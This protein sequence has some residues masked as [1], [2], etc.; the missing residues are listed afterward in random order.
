M[1]RFIG[2][3]EVVGRLG[4]G[5]SGAVFE[6]RDA[7][8]DRSLAIKVLRTDGLGEDQRARF[9]QEAAVLGLLEHEGIARIYHGGRDDDFEGGLPY[10]AMEL[11]R[12]EPIDR[13]A[14]T[15]ELGDRERIE[16]LLEL[17]GAIE[18]AHQ[19]GVIHR[20]LK[21]SN[22]L[23]TQGGQVKV[24]DFGLARLT[25]ADLELSRGQDTRTGDVLGTLPYMSPEQVAARPAELDTRTDVYALGVMAYELLAGVQ[26]IETRSQSL[27]EAARRILEEE[28]TT[29]GR[30]DSRWRGDLEIIVAKA[31]AKEKHQR[32]G[33]VGDFAR[34]LQRYLDH[35]PIAARRPTRSYQIRM[36]ARRQ[37]GLV[38]GLCLA[39]VVLLAGLGTSGSLYLQ[40]RELLA[41]TEVEV[42]TA[43]EVL[44]FVEQLFAN[45][46]PNGE[47]LLVKD[48]VRAA[49]DRIQAEFQQR[50]EVR[51]RLLSLLGRSFNQLQLHDQAMPLLEEALLLQRELHGSR[52][53]QVAHVL[54]QL[55]DVAFH[56][57]RVGDAERLFGQALE[58][59]RECLSVD[60]VIGENLV[61]LGSAM[62]SNGQIEQGGAL[63]DEGVRILEISLG[64][65]HAQTIGSQ[66]SVANRLIF[67]GELERAEALIN[68]LLGI[69][70]KGA[71]RYQ[72]NGRILLADLMFIQERFEGAVAISREA[73]QRSTE[74]FGPNAQQTRKARQALAGKLA[75]TGQAQEAVDIMREIHREVLERYGPESAAAATSLVDL[76]SALHDSP[77]KRE[78]ELAYLEAIDLLSESLGPQHR[79]VF[80]GMHNL[81]Y[82]Y[83]DLGRGEEA[84]GWMREAMEGRDQVFGASN[85]ETLA[86][87]R[88]LAVIL[89]RAKRFE[90]VEELRR[91]SLELYAESRPADSPL[92]QFARQELANVLME[93]E[94]F[95]EAEELL[96]AARAA[97]LQSEESEGISQRVRASLGRLYRAT[98]RADQAQRLEGEAS[99]S[100]GD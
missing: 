48:V 22:V 14:K 84:E 24:L 35:E 77:D 67:E 78:A 83:L 85:I 37:R 33:S 46:D 4:E 75:A 40:T 94:E 29:L 70:V 52:S 66:M 9:R 53:P 81:A 92:I 69:E 100:E 58:I 27:P 1:K 50:P 44:S 49:S 65:E 54:K 32:Y 19:R 10:I 89:F 34:D 63:Q 2:G 90:E 88:G 98:G 41:E 7:K 57:E 12:G 11:V 23:V 76:A 51:A 13:Y 26:P 73:V 28:P 5:G 87:R 31:L 21:P 86:S 56:Q 72:V 91:R 43:G 20:D 68:Q 38:A 59:R 95:D 45:T 55:G 16:L 60:E 30:L 97:L 79:K 15:G 62:A 80:E 82:L 17:C 74:V 8:L 36:F 71:G 25:D 18:H 47:A 99:G 39:F 61:A 42:D 6:A 93:L 64:V 96:L 3:F